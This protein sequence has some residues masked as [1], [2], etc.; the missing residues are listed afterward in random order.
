MRYA[1]EHKSD[2]EPLE[3]FVRRKGGINACVAR[4]SQAGRG[5][6]RCRAIHLVVV[7]RYQLQVPQPRLT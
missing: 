4:F 3:Q 6:P 2:S 5:A 7:G 1:A